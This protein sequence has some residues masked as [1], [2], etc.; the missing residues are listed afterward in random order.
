MKKIQYIIAISLFLGSAAQSINAAFGQTSSQRTQKMLLLE[1][2]SP[3]IETFWRGG[4][5]WA[6]KGEAKTQASV[7]LI[8]EAEA[9]FG[10]KFP[11]RLKLLYERSKGGYTNFAWYPRVSAPGPSFDDWH[12][13]LVNGDL[14]PPNRLETLEQI[15]EMT[16]FG[17]EDLD[18]RNLMANTNRVI[19]L[20]R[21]GWD[22]FLCLDYRVRGPEAEPEVVYYEDD[23]GGLEE[24]LRV[25]DFDTFFSGLR[26]E[27][28]D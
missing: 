6:L 9:K 20:S 21:H 15:A 18:Y 24:R 28:N 8:Q 10:I 26:R 7:E 14:W 13:V 5:H 17:N 11:Q 4:D 2:D 12:Y 25:P 16:D 27:K 22:T 3:S 19:I 1:T 23:G